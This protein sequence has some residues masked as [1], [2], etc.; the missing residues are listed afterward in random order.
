MEIRIVE[1]SELRE[2]IAFYKLNRESMWTSVH[3][4]ILHFFALTFPDC[5]R[6]SQQNMITRVPN[7]SV[8]I[9]K[10]NPYRETLP[11]TRNMELRAARAR[12]S[13]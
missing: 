3:G 13:A 11:G 12:T 10:T 7:L 2:S 9:F 8:K 5:P 4:T 6:L 1:R